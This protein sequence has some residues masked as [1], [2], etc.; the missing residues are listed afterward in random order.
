MCGT[1]NVLTRKECHR[2]GEPLSITVLP[3]EHVGGIWK[4]GAILVMGVDAIFP[5]ICIKTNQPAQGNQFEWHTFWLPQR[6]II[7]L[8]LTKEYQKKRNQRMNIGKLF[9]TLSIILVLGILL[10]KNMFQDQLLELP[11][12]F[13]GIPILFGVGGAIYSATHFQI[14]HVINATKEHVFIK[15]AHPDF[16]NRFPQWEGKR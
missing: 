16:V 12:L 10:L 15:G 2:C 6:P 4:D 3:S 9:F 8:G 5:D 13:F 14:V 1:E 11:A 7:Y